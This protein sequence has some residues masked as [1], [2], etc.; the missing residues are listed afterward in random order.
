MRAPALHSVAQL[1][2]PAPAAA[3]LFFR[4]R[5]KCA[6]F[7]AFIAAAAA[8]CGAPGQPEP[9]NPILPQAVADLAARQQGNTI[10]LTFTLPARSTTNEDLDGPPTVEI[11]R[12]MLAAGEPE[13]K[14][15]THLVYTIPAALVDTYLSGDRLEFRDPFHADDLARQAGATMIYMVRT[16]VSRRH[17]SDDSNIAE[18][19]IFPVPAPPT[20]LH[21]TVTEHAI[22]LAW[23]A[24][25]AGAGISGYRV[26]RGEL[27]PDSPPN[28][29]DLA[30]MKFLSPLALAGP[31][32]EASFDDAQFDF[33]HTYVYTVRSVAQYGPD[34][35]ESDDSLPTVVTPRDTFPPAP[36]RGLEAIYVPATAAAPADIELSWDISPESDLAGYIVYRSEQQGTRGKKLNTELL[37]SPAFRDIQVAA[38]KHYFYSVSAVDRAGNESPLSPEVSAEVP[39]NSP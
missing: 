24:P 38:D 35:I 8:G 20:A 34:G 3:P 22:E 33:G 21:A 16:N 36:P 30:Q 11:Y 1:P 19:R 5:A 14:L 27:A 13:H 6:L 32:S 17:D 4:L 10:I 18:A 23:E 37:P 25:A 7:L 26:Y 31:A 28:Q 29:T 15:T 2:D 9:P 12:G 39:A